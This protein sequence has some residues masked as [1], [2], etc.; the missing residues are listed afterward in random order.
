MKE[1]DKASGK[2]HPQD[3]NHQKWNFVVTLKKEQKFYK[4]SF[5][6]FRNFAENLKGFSILQ[7]WS[8]QNFVVA[9]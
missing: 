1:E 9:S 8:I 4:I 5:L 2:T 6:T 7:S 3:Q